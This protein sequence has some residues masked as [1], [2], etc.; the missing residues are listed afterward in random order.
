MHS[1]ETCA[2]C[3]QRYF[4]VI[5]Y[6]NSCL[7][8][9]LAFSRIALGWTRRQYLEV[10]KYHGPDSPQ[11][12][13]SEIGH[14]GTLQWYNNTTYSKH[15]ECP[16]IRRS[17]GIIQPFNEKIGVMYDP[18]ILLPYEYLSTNIFYYLIQ[19]KTILFF[20]KYTS[21]QNIS[22][23]FVCSLNRCI[24]HFYAFFF[25]CIPVIFSHIRNLTSR[26]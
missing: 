2:Q 5:Y 4:E 14:K 20:F 19:I 18:E 7:F 16:R 6:V 10:L 3:Y 13:P 8:E 21:I 11:S 24:H 17:E 25:Q 12:R 1:N 9:A 23:V 26:M 15:V 22:H